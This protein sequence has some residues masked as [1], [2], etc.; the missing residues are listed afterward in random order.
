MSNER[1]TPPQTSLLLRIFG[2]IYLLY[3]AWD[4]RQ[5]AAG[6]PLYLIPIVIF[7]V[8]GIVLAVHSIRTLATH[9]YFR[10]D[11]ETESSEDREDE[12]NE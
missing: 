4:M 7:A 11:P 9:K 6:N 2:G 3:L 10:K 8:V 5:A 12:S 1:N